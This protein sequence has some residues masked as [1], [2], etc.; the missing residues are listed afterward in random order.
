MN[1]NNVTF[2]DL[3]NEAIEDLY[4]RYQKYNKLIDMINDVNTS[5]EDRLRYYK[6][7]PQEYKSKVKINELGEL[8]SVGLDPKVISDVELFNKYADKG[9]QEPKVPN[10]DKLAQ[11]YRWIPSGRKGTGTAYKSMIKEP[12]STKVYNAYKKFAKLFRNIIDPKITTTVEVD[13]DKYKL[14]SSKF[15]SQKDK[16]IAKEFDLRSSTLYGSNKYIQNLDDKLTATFSKIAKSQKNNKNEYINHLIELIEQYT[17]GKI[18]K[19]TIVVPYSYLLSLAYGDQEQQ[20]AF[21]DICNLL[22]QYNIFY[23][24]KTDEEIEA[25]VY[26]NSNVNKL[27]TYVSEGGQIRDINTM[28]E[29]ERDKLSET[30]DT[31]EKIEKQENID[32]VF[33]KEY[34]NIDK[35]KVL[36]AIKK[37]LYYTDEEWN[38]M[39][40][41][42]KIDTLKQFKDF[43]FKQYNK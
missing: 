1:L 28:S 22:L 4:S 27:R 30:K 8:S 2:N 21:L 39:D 11:L 37:H 10:L 36:N 19:H 32:E 3:F 6:L 43:F 5:K 29:S 41:N 16:D 25:Y 9:W 33:A 40:E 15:R 42:E 7:L 14:K 38:N 35:E 24:P 13:G 18:G 17:E 31:V 12:I 20:L 23:A 34:P 26:F